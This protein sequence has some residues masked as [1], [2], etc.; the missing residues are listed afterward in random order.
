MTRRRPAVMCRL[1]AAAVVLPLAAACAEVVARDAQGVSIDVGFVGKVAPGTRQWFSRL[2]ADEH[3]AQL[4]RD[5][6]L[7]DLRE[8][9]A[10]Y[11]CVE[12]E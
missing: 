7:V 12:P 3:C 8:S 1:A 5:S 10:I 6:K 2:Q 11:R 4:G 9:V